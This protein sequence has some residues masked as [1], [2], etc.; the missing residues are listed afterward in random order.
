MI[1]G[2]CVVLCGACVSESQPA[3]GPEAVGVLRQGSTGGWLPA[4]P[5]PEARARH[6]A[7]LLPDGRVLVAGGCD[8]S[9][10]PIASVYLY[11]PAAEAWTSAAPLPNGACFH[12]ATLL[13]TGEVLVAGGIQQPSATSTSRYDPASD[14]WAPAA[15]LPEPRWSHCAAL[16]SSGA[17]LVVGGS[18]A[19][20]DVASALLYY[21]V[22]DE[23][24]ATGSLAASSYWPACAVL[25][26]GRVLVSGGMT[27]S[28]PQ[29]EVVAGAELYDPAT[30]AW[31]PAAAPSVAR[32][33]HTLTTLPAGEVLA[34]AGIEIAS[35]MWVS[36]AST[37]ALSRS[38]VGGSC[39]GVQVVE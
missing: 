13:A 32:T 15:P 31:S 9:D 26:D 35:D 6:T 2:A 12:A 19:A 21:P 39:D 27:G 14:T 3:L 11:D 37:C 17:V 24:S 38:P 22:A 25:H 10:D 34:A 1:A 18:T 8:R 16:L 7:T 28:D 33:Y 5:I 20:G 29:Y 36:L 4:A 23:W 30:G